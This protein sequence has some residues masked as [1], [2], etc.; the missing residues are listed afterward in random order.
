MDTLPPPWAV[1]IRLGDRLCH[2]PCQATPPPTGTHTH[3]HPSAHPARHQ[4]GFAATVPLR[5]AARYHWHT[6]HHG[7]A[8]L[9]FR[10]SLSFLPFLHA[11]KRLPYAYTSSSVAGCRAAPARLRTRAFGGLTCG[12]HYPSHRCFHLHHNHTTPPTAARVSVC[13][14]LREFTGP[15]FTHT[16]PPHLHCLRDDAFCHTAPTIHW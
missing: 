15:R 16:Y 2:T 14:A 8:P 11:L 7:N 4:Q 10:S 6:A 3:P 13:V 1:Y 9:L 5:A 12:F